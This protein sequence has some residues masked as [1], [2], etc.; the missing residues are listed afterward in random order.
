M[1]VLALGALFAAALLPLA[2]QAA[3][4]DTAVRA[5]VAALAPQLKIDKI[6]P[7]PM[8]GFRQVIVGG[9]VVYVSDDGRYLMQ[10]TLFDTKAK[11][12]LTSARAAI[13]HKTRVDA[14]PQ[15]QRIVFGA[16]GK[17]KYKVTVFT[18]IDCG[19]CRKLHSEIAEINKLGIEV[20]YLFFPRSGP[21]T[22]SFDKAVA[23]WC[24][25]DR[26]A[27]FTAAKAG[28]EPKPAQCD[29]PVAAQ[30]ALGNE[31]GVTGTPTILAPDGSRIGGYLPPDQ[32]LARLQALDKKTPASP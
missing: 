17:P 12:D 10:G 19:Y 7:A 16:A 32:L 2:A 20:D 28:V 5:A 24:A 23:V 27:A 26:K 4:A 11:V 21:N 3:D 22:P 14:V 29:N 18:D 15:D 8:A 13:E 31:V 25:A 6:E 1:G 30:F 9:Q